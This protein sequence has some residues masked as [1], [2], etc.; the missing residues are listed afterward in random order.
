MRPAQPAASAATA[1]PS[2]HRLRWLPTGAVII[3]MEILLPSTVVERS[4]DSNFTPL[5]GFNSTSVK[6][7][8]FL[9]RDI[10][11]PEPPR[12]DLRP[13]FGTRLIHTPP[14]PSTP[15]PFAATLPPRTPPL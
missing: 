9:L 2:G 7:F 5:V 8:R 12:K 11:S 15:V 13:I 14:K 6:A 10:S 1:S 3:G 4:T